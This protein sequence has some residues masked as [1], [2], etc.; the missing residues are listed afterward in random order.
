MTGLWNIKKKR[1]KASMAQVVGVG[2]FTP[3]PIGA[4]FRTVFCTPGRR[5]RTIRDLSMGLRK[6]ADL[7][8]LDS[9]RRRIPPP[10]PE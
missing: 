3:Q 2:Q 8:S 9:P 5:L 1:E 7:D 6:Q 4:D 10:Y